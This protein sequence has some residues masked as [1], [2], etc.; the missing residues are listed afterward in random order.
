[1][2]PAMSRGSSGQARILVSDHVV[3]AEKLLRLCL[4]HPA[5]LR[6]RDGNAELERRSRS[7]LAGDVDP[8]TVAVR[9][10]L[11]DGE[12]EAGSARLTAPARVRTREAPEDPVEIGCGDPGSGVAYGDDGVRVLAANADLDPVAL[13]GVVDRVLDERVDRDGE[14]LHVDTH[15][16]LLRVADRPA[17]RDRFPSADG[18]GD[19]R[20]GGDEGRMQELRVL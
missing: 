12:P 2:R 6:H 7:F 17:S 20:L 19:E 10:R 5:W 1:M 14:P 3:A 9:D 4:R 13:L 15:R 16:R 8:T 18:V 11:D